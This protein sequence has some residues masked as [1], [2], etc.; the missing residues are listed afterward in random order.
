MAFR[1]KFKA[2]KLFLNMISDKCHR[3]MMCA[4]PCVC[5]CVYG[6]EFLNVCT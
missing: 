4:S 3:E 6:S 5:V 2:I 1:Y